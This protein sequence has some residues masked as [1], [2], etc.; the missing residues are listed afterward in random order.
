MLWQRKNGNKHLRDNF[1]SELK[2]EG[3]PKSGDSLCGSP[4]KTQ[5]K[6]YSNM[7]FLK[8]TLAS[9][10]MEGNLKGDCSHFT[11]EETLRE[12][13]SADE[14]E[15]I[16]SETPCD[17]SLS[18]S[19]STS[20]ASSMSRKR[21]NFVAE[22]EKLDIERQKL[23][24]MKSLATKEDEKDTTFHF[25]MSLKDPINSLPLNSQM[26]VRYKIQEVVMREIEKHQ[27]INVSMAGL[28]PFNYTDHYVVPPT[29]TSI[30]P[31]GGAATLFST[32][33]SIQHATDE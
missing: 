21:K 8:G 19:A 27:K 32:F 5:W 11:P 2:K 9:R 17:V 20:R 13:E 28:Q 1:R 6:W 29:S 30:N 25:L 3:K 7:E 10:I 14:G 18:S 26:F 4:C 33:T 24:I 12:I 16:R 31:E 15:L 22:G 23:D